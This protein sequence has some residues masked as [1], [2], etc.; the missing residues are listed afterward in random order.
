MIDVFRMTFIVLG[1]YVTFVVLILRGKLSFF[2]NV[3]SG[4]LIVARYRGFET[5]L[6]M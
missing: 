2:S 3:N 5:E 4:H 6:C 1:G